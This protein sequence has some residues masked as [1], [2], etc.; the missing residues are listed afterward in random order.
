M[1]VRRGRP[2]FLRTTIFPTNKSAILNVLCYPA[3]MDTQPKTIALYEEC[4]NAQSR[5]FLS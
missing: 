5:T 3:G 4:R 1:H 2:D